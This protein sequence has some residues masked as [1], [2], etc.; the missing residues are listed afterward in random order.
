MSLAAVLPEAANLTEIAPGLLVPGAFAQGIP[1]NTLIT[2]EV[3]QSVATPTCYVGRGL[4]TFQ[5]THVSLQGTISFGELTAG[6]YDLSG[7]AL[8]KFDTAATQNA[9]GYIYFRLQPGTNTGYT[10]ARFVS[11]NETYTNGVLNLNFRIRFPACTLQIV[12]IY[13]N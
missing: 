11:Y 8:L 13:D 4:S 3:A 1:L 2:G 6:G 7:A 9:L 10:Q 5:R 12:A